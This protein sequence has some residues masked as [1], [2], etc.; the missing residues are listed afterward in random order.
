[1][2]VILYEDK[3]LVCLIPRYF[4]HN[5]YDMN[6]VLTEFYS[7]HPYETICVSMFS[8]II[9]SLSINQVIALHNAICPSFYITKILKIDH[10]VY[11]ESDVTG[12]G[13]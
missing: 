5:S 7:S 2:Y 3:E 10:A 6:N 9:R 13:E 11:S 4:Q 8:D 1:M 12:E